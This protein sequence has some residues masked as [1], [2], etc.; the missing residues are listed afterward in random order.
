MAKN[1]VKVAVVGF[2]YWGPNMVRNF[3]AQSNGEVL[4]VADFRKERLDIVNKMYPS[5][6]TT[7]SPDEAIM[8]TET[9]AVIIATPVFTHFEL[10][11]RALNAGKHVLLEKPMVST[12]EEAEILINLAQQK[13][14]TI[15]VDHTFLYTGA[16]QSIKG[17]VD[18]GMIGKLQYIDSTRINLGL[19]QSDV[20]VLW[21]LA[22]HDISILNYL[23]DERPH[24]VQATGV[25]HTNNG[26]ENIAYLTMNYDS[27]M[28][29]HFN[30]SWTSPVKIRK[31]L[32]GG[33]KKMIVFDDTEPT[34]KIR[35]YDTSYHYTE[36]RSDE[37]KRK[38]LVDYRVGDIQIPK[39]PMKE[40][41]A[42]V[43]ADF[44][45]AVLHK[46]TP[47]SDYISGINVIKVLEASQESIKNG[48]KEVKVEYL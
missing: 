37:D 19:F 30:C 29:A 8:D 14:V 36:K 25:S 32:I 31:F 27:N 44:I 9:D 3:N 42:G 38:V 13:G 48:G 34:E 28:I 46:T 16:V 33:D 41:L 39:V 11:K 5:I 21:D 43:A 10:A 24:S 7:Q 6:K 18:T 17:L 20:N 1:T 2:G 22:P 35:V 40:A 4:Y 12:S 47:I 15:M 26:I 45:S 23:T